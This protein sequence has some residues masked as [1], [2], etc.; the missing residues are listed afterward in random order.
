MRGRG[1]A[2]RYD[3]CVETGGSCGRDG[4]REVRL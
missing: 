1:I 2:G 3:D 4:D